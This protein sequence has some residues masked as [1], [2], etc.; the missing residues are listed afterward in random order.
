LRE[1]FA[2]CADPAR[3]GH[4][5]SSVA[6]V[7]D[8]QGWLARHRRR[9]MDG[10]A[11][12]SRTK[13]AGKALD[14]RG[15]DL[16]TVAVCVLAGLVHLVSFGVLATG[17]WCV[18]VGPVMVRILG[19]LLVL[20]GLL[21]VPKP[22]WARKLDGLGR[23][24]LPELFGLL[25]RICEHNKAPVPDLVFVTAE[26]NASVVRWGRRQ[27]L[28]I[29]APLWVAG[30]PS[31][32]LAVLAHEL[33]HLA[34]RDFLSAWWT[35]TAHRSL[36]QWRAFLVELGQDPYGDDEAG[37]RLV[38]LTLRILVWPLRALLSGYVYLMELLGASSSRNREYLADLDAISAGGSAGAVA[39]FDVVLA[40]D[41]V[42][43]AFRRASFRGDE[44][45][46]EEVRT[47]MAREDL[48]TR[49]RRRAVAAQEQSRVDDS[50]PSTAQRIRLV[51][52][53]EQ[54]A[55]GVVVDTATWHRLDAEL[56]PYLLQAGD[57]LARA[58]RY[59][60]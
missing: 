24:D 19:V 46:L 2:A 17:L 31:G 16:M 58:V 13:A 28:T 30:T 34:H 36:E 7:T 44:D 45:V 5:C 55:P 49:L 50:H 15:P 42:E 25:D 54:V 56:E 9:L 59:Q 47:T 12:R 20:F 43:A 1:A 18:W 32:R 60:H 26:F 40:H 48:P 27:F 4:C 38:T 8:D 57:E 3:P 21:L 29:G 23:A 11:D 37:L 52:E 22:Q 51:E 6:P 14:A 41:A 33:G 53:R 39:A 10:Y 35:G